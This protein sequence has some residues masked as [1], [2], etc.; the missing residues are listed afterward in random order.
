MAR[1]WT[2]SSHQWC[3]NNKV[4]AGSTSRHPTQRVIFNARTLLHSALSS[5]WSTE[6]DS[7]R[8]CG[9]V[10]LQSSNILESRSSLGAS[11]QLGPVG[12]LMGS[13]RRERHIFAQITQ[14]LW[15]ALQAAPGWGSACW[16][17]PARGEAQRFAE[18][19][20]DPIWQ[21]PCRYL[22]WAPWCTVVEQQVE[23]LVQEKMPE[24]VERAATGGRYG[25]ARRF[26]N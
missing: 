7:Q 1:D 19:A 20:R 16:P 23:R 5:E 11:G 10:L 15:V 17:E 14:P 22:P 13:G 4:L 24:P 25:C 21:R 9:S 18:P 2:H 26:M 12:D 8:L 3:S 6:N